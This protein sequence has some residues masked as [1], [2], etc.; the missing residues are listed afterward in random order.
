MS[1]VESFSTTELVKAHAQVWN[2]M[3]N[4]ISSSTVKCAVEL[5][6]PDVLF[7]HGKPMC[8]SDISAQLP[9]L[10][11]SKIAFLPILMRFLVHAGFLNQ[12]ENY[13]YFS[14]TP[15]SRLLVKNEPLNVRP[16]LFLSHDP[17]VQKSWFE[18]SSWFQDDSPNA[19]HTAHGKSFWDYV[20]DTAKQD[21]KQLGHLFNDAMAS[22]SRLMTDVIIT[23]CRDVFSGLTS[24]VDVGGG[25]GTMA[26]AIAKAFPIMKCVV[27]D[28]SNVIGDRKDINSENNLDFVG[29][30]MFDEI[31][32]ANAILLKWILHDWSDEDCVKILKV[33]KESIPSRDKGGKLILIIDEFGRAQHFMDLVMMVLYGTKER[34]KKEWE[35]LFNEAGFN[36]Y[37]IPSLGLMSLIEIYS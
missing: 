14:L 22:D 31:P 2:H 26:T 19:F 6:I 25:T 5:D 33:C 28:L 8:L 20:D 23:E 9:L 34:T 35:K 30:S 16:L 13:C 10:H 17:I 36:E 18:L 3:Y 37:K 24:L 15:A 11:P 4:F 1:G 27:L 29:G 21:S 32:H 7:K 12:H